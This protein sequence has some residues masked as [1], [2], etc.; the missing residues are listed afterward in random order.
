MKKLILALACMLT[1]G[2]T[3][4]QENNDKKF[5]AE[6]QFGNM[7][8]TNYSAISV[9]SG[10]AEP[11]L[12]QSY[13][14]NFFYYPSKNF[15][16]TLSCFVDGANTSNLALNEMYGTTGFT[17]GNRY[18]ASISDRSELYVGIG[19]GMAFANNRFSYMDK[20]YTINRIG[21]RFN[22]GI[23]YRYFVNPNAYIGVSVNYSGTSYFSNYKLPVNMSNQ[24]VNPKS[25]V[26]GLN[27]QIGV[28]VKF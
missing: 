21:A 6:L 20:D 1:M 19:V 7:F 22:W 28:G 12:G 2:V 14:A 4:A 11:T 17:F 10:D 27:F 15:A 9:F 8:Y 23:G 18:I 16:W 3:I 13:N 26:Q 25:G 24:S 5:G